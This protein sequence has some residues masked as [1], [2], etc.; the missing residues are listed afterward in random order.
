MPHHQSPPVP[1]SI[2]CDCDFNW[3]SGAHTIPFLSSSSPSL[4]VDLIHSI[5]LCVCRVYSIQIQAMQQI[6]IILNLKCVFD[7]G[8]PAHRKVNLLLFCNSP[9]SFG[10]LIAVDRSRKLRSLQILQTKMRRMI[11]IE[12]DRFCSYLCCHRIRNY[13]KHFYTFCILMGWLLGWRLIL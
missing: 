9:P 5:L 7:V 11:A 8:T 4:Y 13:C 12:S 1:S 6:I 2:Q 10:W 3:A